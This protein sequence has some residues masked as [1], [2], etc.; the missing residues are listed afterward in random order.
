M[1]I[2]VQ[3]NENVIKDMSDQTVKIQQGIDDARH[4]SR[5]WNLEVPVGNIRAEVMNIFTALAPEDKEKV[6]FLFDT[7]HRVGVPWDN[8][9]W[10]VIS[11]FTVETFRNK[12][13]KI[14]RDNKILKEQKEVGYDQLWKEERN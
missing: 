3:K 11:Q 9:T 7:V 13:R 12:I 6:D 10:P 1:E 8:S 4:Y 14:S 5:W 2:H